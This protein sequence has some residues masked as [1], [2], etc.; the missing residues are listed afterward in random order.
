MKHNRENFNGNADDA[1]ENPGAQERIEFEKQEAKLKRR[2]IKRELEMWQAE[3]DLLKLYNAYADDAPAARYE[4][5]I[6]E[7]ERHIA[8]L[9][10][11]FKL[12]KKL[13]QH[14]SKILETTFAHTL[15]ETSHAFANVDQLLEQ[16]RPHMESPQDETEQ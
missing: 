2:R 1:A 11:Q 9:K 10:E 12:V 15:D 16:T 6:A 3:I 5:Q 13:K 4:K 7:L 14:E 8:E